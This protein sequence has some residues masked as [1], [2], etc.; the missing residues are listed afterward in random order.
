MLKL[1]ETDLPG[2]SPESR[3]LVTYH[4]RGGST[5]FCRLAPKPEG[6]ASMAQA[7][8]WSAGDLTHQQTPDAK[9]RHTPSQ[10]QKAPKPLA[11]P[12]SEGPWPTSTALGAG[13][14]RLDRRH[15]NLVSVGNCADARS[16]VEVEESIPVTS[17]LRRLTGSCDLHA[18][19]EAHTA[20]QP[21]VAFMREAEEVCVHNRH[22]A[23]CP[24]RHIVIWNVESPL[25]R[26]STVPHAGPAK[27]GMELSMP[28]SPSVPSQRH[29]SLRRPGRLATNQPASSTLAKRLP[30]LMNG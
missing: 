1:P 19:D 8:Q 29:E 7:R 2:S 11:P 30:S 21:A 5:S 27:S 26:P 20:G 16:L 14:W 24:D 4:L 23:A 22:E 28:S 13:R 25:D 17:D 3:G 10:R 6:K 18:A 12:S 9:L 15:A